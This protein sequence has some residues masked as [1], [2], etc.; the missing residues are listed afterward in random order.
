MEEIRIEYEQQLAELRACNERLRL[1]MAHEREVNDDLEQEVLILKKQLES[2][3]K[4]GMS[5]EQEAYYQNL[6]AQYSTSVSWR[7]TKPVRFVGRILKKII[8]RN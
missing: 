5:T 7:I 8:R 1:A 6:I 2:E 4:I 3:T